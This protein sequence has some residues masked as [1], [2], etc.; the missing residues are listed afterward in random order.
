M[1]NRDEEEAEEVLTPTPSRHIGRANQDPKIA[2]PGD[3]VKTDAASLE[4]MRA[5]AR[6]ISSGMGD[7]GPPKAPS[8]KLSGVGETY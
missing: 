6:R 7:M 1:A 8:R 2:L 3:E 5:A 4:R